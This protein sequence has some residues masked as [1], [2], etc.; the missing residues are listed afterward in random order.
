ME[1]ETGAWPGFRKE[2]RTGKPPGRLAVSHLRSLACVLP[3]CLCRPVFTASVCRR[4]AAATQSVMLSLHGRPRVLSERWCLS[5]SIPGKE[6][7]IGRNPPV[8]SVDRQHG[9]HLLNQGFQ[10]WL[11]IRVTSGRFG[12]LFFRTDPGSILESTA[13]GA[14]T[15][16]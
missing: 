4:H 5:E 3:L 10:V 13:A 16:H 12:F 8:L 11:M 15:P 14:G 7:L 1:A 9:G 6:N 2:L